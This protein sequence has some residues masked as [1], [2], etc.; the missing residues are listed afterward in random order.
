MPVD[1]AILIFG[2][3]LHQ[4]CLPVIRGFLSVHCHRFTADKLAGQIDQS[5]FCMQHFHQLVYR[6]MCAASRIEPAMISFD[7]IICSTSSYAFLKEVLTCTSNDED[8]KSKTSP[9]QGIPIAHF[10]HLNV[11]P[12]SPRLNFLYSTLSICKRSEQHLCVRQPQY[13]HDKKC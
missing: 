8:L 7:I 10:L 12:I 1:V 3:H 2:P 5:S 9:L 11:T 4:L 6:R 13:V